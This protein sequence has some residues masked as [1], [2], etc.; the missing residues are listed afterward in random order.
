MERAGQ[1]RPVPEALVSAGAL[2]RQAARLASPWFTSHMAAPVGVPL[3]FHALMPLP[4]LLL[5]PVTLLLGPSAA[6]NLMVL[7]VPGLLCYAMY[8]AARL[9]LP[10]GA[11]AVAAGAFFGLSAML[12]EQA[13]YH[14][15]IAAGAVFLPLVAEASV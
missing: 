6:Y 5:S 15:N 7:L 12:T 4:G 9:W 14:L 8:R 3:G 10:P 2:A 13:W 11:G 1:D